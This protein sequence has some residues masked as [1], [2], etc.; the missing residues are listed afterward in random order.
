MAIESVSATKEEAICNLL[1]AFD[2]ACIL[3][4]DQMERVSLVC[5]V[6]ERFSRFI[7]FFQGFQ[8][9]FDDMA[10]ICLDVPLAYIMLD[11]FID[12]CYKEG[13]LTEKIIKNMPTR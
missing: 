8:R 13:F 6:V 3:S 10:D 1:K 4:T 5:F 7:I 11:R 12:R 2:S 9:V